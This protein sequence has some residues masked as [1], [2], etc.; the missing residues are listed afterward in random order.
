MPEWRIRSTSYHYTPVRRYSLEQLVEDV[1][2]L[3]W[4]VLS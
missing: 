3:I 1:G 4:G 2:R